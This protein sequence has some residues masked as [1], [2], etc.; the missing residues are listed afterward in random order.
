[1]VGL[2][3]KEN[4]VAAVT[5]VFECFENSWHIVCRVVV[6]RVYGATRSY[7]FIR[8]TDVLCYCSW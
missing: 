3:R 6:C 1:M 4:D 8:A 2:V 5:A 7:T